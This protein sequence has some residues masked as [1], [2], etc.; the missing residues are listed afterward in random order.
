MNARNDR[1][2][3]MALVTCALLLPGWQLSGET[4]RYTYDSMQR[5]TRVVYE[6]GT[7]VDYLYDNMGNRLAK[8]TSPS[9]ASQN[10]P[11]TP[12]GNPGI[13]DGAVNISTSP[14]LSWAAGTDPE[15]DPIVYTVYLGTTRT[16]PL[17]YTGWQPAFAAADLQCFTTYYWQVIARDS[18]NAQTTGPVWSFTTGNKPPEA[19]FFATPSSGAAPLKVSFRDQTLYE[20][21]RLTSWEWDFNGD[22]VIDST[23]QNPTHTYA[24]GGNYNVTLTVRDEHGGVNSV[25]QPNYVSVLGPNMVDLAALGLRVESAAS[26]G[27]LVVSYAVTNLGVTPFLGTVP[28]YDTLYLSPSPALDSRAKMAGLFAENRS[29]LPG[30]AY[31]RTNLVGAQ[32]AE[33]GSLYLLLKADGENSIPEI[34]EQNNVLSVSLQSR[35]PDLVPGGLRYSGSAVVGQSLEITYAVTNQGA[36]GITGVAGAEAEWYDLVYLST[37][38]TWDATATTI[39]FANAGQSLAPGAGCLVTNSA[40]LPAWPPGDYYLLVRVDA[41]NGIV[42]SNPANNTLAL[43]LSL[44]APDLAPFSVSAPNGLPSD[45]LIEIVSVV[46]NQSPI[47]AEGLFGIWND[48][49]YLSRDAVLDADDHRLVEEYHFEAVEGNGSYSTTNTVRLPG[50]PAGGYYLILSVDTGNWLAEASEKNNSL[51]RPLTVAAPAGFPDLAPLDLLAPAVG[52]PGQSI[53]V[54]YSVT[55][56]GR[57]PATGEWIDG[58]WLSTD[59]PG[60][61][62]KRLVGIETITNA[63]ANDGA[64]SVSQTVVLPINISGP[65]YLT[66]EVDLFGGVFEGNETNNALTRPLTLELPSSLPDLIPA[67]LEVPGSARAGGTIQVSYEIR[68]AGA[69]LAAG[70]WMDTLSLSNAVPEADTEPFGVQFIATPVAAG[71]SY[72][73]T[74]SATIPEDL[75]SGDYFVLLRANGSLGILEASDRNNTLTAPIFIDEAPAGSGP[76]LRPVKF[77]APSAG[78]PGDY[79]DFSYTITNR[80]SST[81]EGGYYDQVVLSEDRQWDDTDH[82]LSDRERVLPVTAG[83]SYGYSRSAKLPDW[84]LGDYF[85]ILRS[86]VWDDA[87]EVN[88]ENNTLVLPIT[89][90]AARPLRFARAQLAPDGKL[91]LVIEATIGRKYSLRVSSDLAAWSVAREWTCTASPETVDIPFDG[92]PRAQFFRLSSP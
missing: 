51:A 64:Y 38:A 47:A 91:R 39:G 92:G 70:S 45:R 31:A 13:P 11:P 73:R 41:M 71:S 42:E 69:A 43:P 33:S 29:L 59:A 18:R 26:Y 76:D 4:L 23:L 54:T 53:Q 8:T 7:R 3:W 37:N 66:V 82:V 67:S 15:G 44:S 32:A 61:Q 19:G 5:L 46:T 72:R 14:T 89:L 12:A 6:D 84:D 20:C 48:A 74:F 55:N 78:M 80:G 77:T 50:W 85:L 57:M 10:A 9:S 75:Q 88:E 56:S 40:Q 68:N 24:A 58:L 25:T 81:V 79:L 34:N 87:P 30:T 35:L 65:C 36:L 62:H 86:D 2:L 83:A 17:A 28:W 63:V 1:P 22:G 90:G 60:G 49:L 16:P 52:T 27:N 21:G